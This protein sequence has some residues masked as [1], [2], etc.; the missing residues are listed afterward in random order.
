MVVLIISALMLL[1]VS[2]KVSYLQ[3]AKVQ[4]GCLGI[5][6]TVIGDKKKKKPKK[7]KTV[8][9]VAKKQ[10]TKKAKQK[11]KKYTPLELIELILDIIKS[12]AGPSVWLARKIRVKKLKTVIIVA[13]DDCAKTAQDYGKTCAVVYG[14]VGYLQNQIKMTVDN[15][16]VGLDFQ[17]N[18]TEYE[19]CF[20]LK[21]RLCYVVYALI[22]ML[23]RFIGN[24]IKKSI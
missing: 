2:V 14:A 21:I 10:G 22:R 20:K 23:T 5:Y 17:K 18:K 24:T 19:I 15:V 3:N 9:Q 11:K 6:F 7:R 1:D 16:F 13:G 8:R 12:V 4:I